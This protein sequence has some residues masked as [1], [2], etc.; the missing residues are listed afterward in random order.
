MK[1]TIKCET[2]GEDIFKHLDISK[3]W[4]LLLMSQRNGLG[5]S[6]ED[7]PIKANWTM[8]E[9]MFLELDAHNDDSHPR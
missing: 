8:L 9:N 4:H 6:E 3:Q 1:C 2:C 7:D 5:T